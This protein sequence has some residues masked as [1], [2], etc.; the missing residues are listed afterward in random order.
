M[1]DVYDL[2]QPGKLF[3]ERDQPFGVDVCQD[4]AEL[5]DSLKGILD[6]GEIPRQRAA[7]RDP[8]GEPLHDTP[9]IG[10]TNWNGGLTATRHLLARMP[11]YQI[12]ER[13]I[14]RLKSEF[15]AGIVGLPALAG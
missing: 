11:E 6:G 12:V 5:I 3:L 15:V 10:A 8:T 13:D 2:R 7:R 1:N 4:S 9:S 14:E